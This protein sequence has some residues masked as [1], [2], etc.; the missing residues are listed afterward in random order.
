MANSRARTTCARRA[1]TRPGRTTSAPPP[2]ASTRRAGKTPTC[3]TPNAINPGVPEMLATGE[4]MDGYGVLEVHPEG[5][6]FLRA[7]NYLPGNKDVYVSIAQIRRFGLRNGDYVVGKT[8]P[9]RE[10]DRYNAMIYISEINGEAPEKAIR[11]KPFESLVP[12]YPDERLR[13]EDP[14]GHSDLAL[15]LIDMLAP[16]GKGRGA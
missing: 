11:R 6:G 16:I 4:C 10:G 12:I 3:P 2:R 1:R 15:R 8:R 7:E 5:Y 9:Q 14:N 13:L